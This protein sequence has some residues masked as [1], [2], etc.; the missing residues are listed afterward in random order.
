MSWF[1]IALLSAA[2]LGLVGILDKALLFHF[3]KSWLTLP[4]LIGIAQGAIGITLLLVLPWTD[5]GAAAI[6]WAVLSGLLWGIGSLFLFYLLFE[7]EASKTIPIFQTFPAF[8]APMAVIF[9]GEDLALYQWIAILAVVAGAVMNS[10]KRDA[11]YGGLSL[12]GAFYVL[13]A[14]SVLAAA[15][16]IAGKLAVDSMEVLAAHAFRVSGMSSLMLVFSLRRAPMRE[17]WGFVRSRS[18]ALGIFGLN[19]FVVA[20]TGMIINLWAI[21]LGPVSLV[22]AVTATTSLF[23]LAYGFALALVFKGA[24][25]E[26]I[27]AGS[28]AI[29]VVSTATMVVG[30]ALIA[31]E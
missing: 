15:A 26:Q 11:G 1:W 12:D 2:L 10:M 28:V 4:L 17:V 25:G 20:N 5:A 27:S 13:I 23:L 8:V 7:R 6:G 18:P 29:K 24:L 19:E 3:A 30:V 9:L 22:T 21:S 31:I 14:A 16:N